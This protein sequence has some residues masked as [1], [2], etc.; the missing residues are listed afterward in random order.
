MVLLV[1]M[2]MPA[3]AA[4]PATSST[5]LGIT[6]AGSAVTTVTSPAAI[7]L[8]A[9]T[10]ANT[11]PVTQGVVNF[12]YST[13]LS[14]TGGALVGTAQLT[15]AGTASISIQPAVGSHSYKA[16]F[17]GTTAVQGSASAA[18]TV[19]VSAAAT[20]TIPTTA[21]IASTGTA[22]N[23]TL[24]GTVV[25]NGTTAPSGL[26]NFI[27]VTNGNAS[28]GSV[29]LASAVT[30][31]GFLIVPATTDFKNATPLA[32][33]D[34]NGDGR[35]D[36]ISVLSDGSVV[37]QLGNGDG[38]FTTKATIPGQASQAAVGDFN[39]DGKLD[40]AIS[41]NGAVQ[42]FLGDGTG[43]FT[44]VT[45]G[46][47][48]SV[49]AAAMAVGDFNN[50]G[51]LDLA[52]ADAQNAYFYLGNGD[53]TFTAGYNTTI[54]VYTQGFVFSGASAMATGDF[55]GDGNTDLA[56]AANL[57]GN[58]GGDSV[59]FITY[60]LGDG[61]GNF[62][63]AYVNLTQ[64][65]PTN[66]GSNCYDPLFND[67]P[68]AM[69]IAAYDI[70]GDGLVD[71]AASFLVVGCG[72][73]GA[74]GGSY[75]V[76]SN[77]SGTF[78]VQNV[79]PEF[80]GPPVAQAAL[81]LQGDGSTEL[82][83]RGDD[84]IP[85]PFDFF[86]PAPGHIN[87]AQQ[88]L[89][90]PS[91]AGTGFVT[92]DFNGDGI[93]DIAIGGPVASSIVGFQ[94]TVT[95]V[96]DAVAV[97]PAGTG[98]H[99]VEASYPGDATHVA[100]VSATAALASGKATPAI[101][102]SA[103]SVMYGSAAVI[104]ATLT[105]GGNAPTG[106][107]TFF[108]NGVSAGSSM[109]SSGKATFTLNSLMPGTY[110][111][112]ASYSGD[113]YNAAASASAISLNVTAQTSSLAVTASATTTT[114]GSAI[115]LTATMH[116]T[117]TAPSGSSI[118]FMNGSATL[119][120]SALNTSGIATLTVA[121]PGL[122]VGSDSITASFAGNTDFAATTSAPLIV[123][124]AQQTPALTLT[125]PATSVSYG[126]AITFTAN[127]KVNGAPPAG[128]ITFNNGS[129]ALG[130]VAPN[131]SGVAT[132]IVAAPG[133]PVGSDSIT[134]LFVGDSNYSAVMS[135]AVIV[136][137]AAPTFAVT[138]PSLTITAGA[139][140]GDTVPVTI[141]PQA[142][143]TGTVDLAVQLT[144]SP[145]N[146]T[147]PPAAS[148]GANSMVTVTGNSAVTAT[149]TVTTTAPTTSR[150]DGSGSPDRL[151]W[152]GSGGA[153]LACVFFVGIPAR[154]WKLSQLRRNTMLLLVLLVSFAA[155]LSACGGSSHQTTTIPGTTAGAYVFTVTATSGSI[156][157]TGTV[158]VTVK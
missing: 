136:T 78:T 68:G 115:T 120:S 135:A 99:Q 7:V 109:V 34:F 138:V 108:N 111:I 87:Y 69:S 110:P 45:T 10:I 54:A 104:T 21:T 144:S 131:S 79:D 38:S 127:L 147:D 36:L 155:A 27:D 58:P 119:G 18:S 23:Y 90:L 16:I 95:A 11:L 9:T 77:G 48:I 101:V 112:T 114:Y 105:S 39:S 20:Q 153:V 92:G 5:S 84:N 129:T 71:L 13:Q 149:L 32:S 15:A 3:W 55:D 25:G 128:N 74:A 66:P 47:A 42:I 8:T 117:G 75:A 150:N 37:S 52:L 96:A 94:T 28:V 124:V 57:V 118:T 158:T 91:E 132:L 89:L 145:P 51:N 130:S 4:P 116:V 98:T 22:G 72:G 85:D 141:T 139:S 30:Q 137:V 122:P 65:Y 50:D 133:L 76:L 2:A 157:S 60:L 35:P 49:S 62:T 6:S 126:S 103:P 100:S 154:K 143:F 33:G 61:A 44:A 81:D 59:F 56:V 97:S 17:A 156:S 41:A 152:L 107:V 14:C 93:P 86:S 12:C 46:A 125:T 82:V 146:A 63:P 134:A 151:R 140:T 123:T 1:V 31:G 106:T 19:T 29:T 43:N 113:T 24:T 142:G 121:A 64:N 88:Q 148:F 83:V 67:L 102:L 40:V 73:G 80:Y 26:L 70:N 53:G